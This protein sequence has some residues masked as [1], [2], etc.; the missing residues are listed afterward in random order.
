MTDDRGQAFLRDIREQRPDHYE[1]V[2]RLREI[3]LASG[4][5]IREKVKYGGLLFS[6]TTGFCGVFSYTHHVTLEFSQGA[7]LP[8]PYAV[9]AG[10]GKHR[11]HIKLFQVSDIDAKHVAQYIGVARKAADAK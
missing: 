7:A 8:D 4:P 9:L 6:S 10:A 3:A 1:V 11:R 2:T 5:D